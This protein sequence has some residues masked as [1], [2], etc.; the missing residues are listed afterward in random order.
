VSTRIFSVDTNC[1][2]AAVCSWHEH[3]AAAAAEIERRLERG[4]QL[5]VPAPALVEAYA[6]LTRLPPPHRLGPDDAWTLLEANFVSD[7]AVTA[8][9]AASYTR[10]LRRLAHEKISGGRTYDAVIGECVRQAE[11]QALLT[12]NRKHFDPPPDGVTVIEPPRAK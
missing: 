2:V 11:S 3:H 9:N 12:F 6:V 4:E 8:L 5:T 1:M 7:A 10:L